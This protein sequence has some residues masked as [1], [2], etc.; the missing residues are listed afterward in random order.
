MAKKIYLLNNL[1][2]DGV[3]NLEVF[4]I[5]YISSEIDINKYDALIFTSKNA[6][7]A[8]DSFN[9]DWRDIDSYAIAPKTAN[10]IQKYNGNLVFTGVSS[11]GDSFASELCPL[12][13]DKKVL[14]VRASKTV[15]D[16]TQ[17][18]KSDN[19]DIDELIA[20][21]TSCKKVDKKLENN[22]I[23]VFTSPSSVQCFLKNYD[24]NES[25][26]AVCIGETTAKYLPSE[27]N[28]KISSK[29][30]I[31]ECIKVAQELQI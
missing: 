26:L 10:V 24:W 12:L 22:S 25:Y 3:E 1:K 16:L 30:S 8:I 15:S 14:Y 6:I 7:Y 5:E 31:E 2:Y 23:F 11:H 18:L 9:K 27:I 17:I 4:G 20:Y 29:T 19:I 28:Y 13:K 21:K